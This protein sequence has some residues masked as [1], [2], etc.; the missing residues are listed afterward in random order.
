MPVKACILC[1][2]RRIQSLFL[3]QV[4]SVEIRLY[5]NIG[6]PKIPLFLVWF[7]LALRNIKTVLGRFA[8][9]TC[10]KRMRLVKL[11]HKKGHYHLVCSLQ[12][13]MLHL[14]FYAFPV[15]R[16]H[17]M[18]REN[19]KFSPQGYNPWGETR[20]KNSFTVFIFCQVASTLVN[21]ILHHFLF[22]L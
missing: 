18:H 6:R 21:P 19:R 20:C 7:S 1:L 10:K 14:S 2:K 11:F 5:Y 15:K 13:Y 12:F 16:W 3:R 17:E 22:S 4:T 8:Q 9:R